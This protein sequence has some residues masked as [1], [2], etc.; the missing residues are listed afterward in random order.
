MTLNGSVW[1]AEGTIRIFSNDKIKSTEK[2]TGKTMV[3]ILEVYQPF[4]DGCFYSWNRILSY[5]L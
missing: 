5:L 2:K 3:F 1:T 4:R